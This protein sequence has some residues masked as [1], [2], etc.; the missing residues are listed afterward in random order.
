MKK[1]KLKLLF[2]DFSSKKLTCYLIK[3]LLRKQ[4]PFFR[5]DLR[6]EARGKTQEAEARGK[7][8]EA[9][10]R[11]RRQ[12]AGGKRQEARGKRQEARGRR[13]EERGERQEGES[14]ALLFFNNVLK[15][16][17]SRFVIV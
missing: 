15:K 9:E 14:F 7:R 17:F 3:R 11:G 12:E 2:I 6:Q 4:W 1:E 10:A 16:V 5:L 13:Q 8:Q